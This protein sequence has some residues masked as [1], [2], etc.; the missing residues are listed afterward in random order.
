MNGTHVRNFSY[1]M[2][3]YEQARSSF[4]SGYGLLTT[5]KSTLTFTQMSS[6]TGLVVDS[7]VFQR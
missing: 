2:P 4:P 7:F 6:R 1:P 5:N 3:L